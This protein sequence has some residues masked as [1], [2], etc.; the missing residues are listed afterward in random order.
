M[1]NNFY[2]DFRV[3]KSYNNSI[4][5][6]SKWCQTTLPITNCS[7]T[8]Y[9]KNVLNRSM[10]LQKLS[11]KKRKKKNSYQFS[12]YQNP[13]YSTFPSKKKVLSNIHSTTYLSLDDGAENGDEGNGKAD[14]HHGVCMCVGGCVHVC[15]HYCV[16]LLLDSLCGRNQAHDWLL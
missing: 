11:P 1:I 7:W 10:Y 4:I 14:G 16:I 9:L 5:L 13:L 2:F 3:I 12:V 6:I 15:R 8:L